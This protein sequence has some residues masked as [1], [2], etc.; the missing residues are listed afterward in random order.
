MIFVRLEFRAHQDRGDAERLNGKKEEPSLVRCSNLFV[1]SWGFISL[2]NGKDGF[3]Q[4]QQPEEFGYTGGAIYAFLSSPI[5]VRAI[6][7]SIVAS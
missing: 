2:S 3:G 4:Q 1:D 6:C 7:V 5:R